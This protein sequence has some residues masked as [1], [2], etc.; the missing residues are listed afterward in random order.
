MPE[1]RYYSGP[2]ALMFTAK[3][4]EP[5]LWSLV[6]TMLWIAGL[7][8]FALLANRFLVSVPV[9][10][11]DRVIY[12]LAAGPLLLTALRRP[13][14]LQPAGSVEKVMAVYVAVILVSWGTTLPGKD[15]AG[16]KQDADF[17]LT[18]FVMPF[19]AFLIAR[20]TAWTRERILASLWVLVGGV[21][22][23][24]LL[25]GAMQYTYDWNFLVPEALQNI[26]PDRAKGPFENAVPYGVVLSMLVPLALF[27][28]VQVRERWV[29]IVPVVIAVGLVQSIIASKTRAV[30][31]ALPVALLFPWVRYP[32]VRLLSALLIADLALQVLLAPA[33][34][35]DPWGLR[36]RLLQPEPVYDRVA[37]SATASN[38]IEHR[39]LFGFGFGMF[40][41]RDDK[42]DYY[43]SWGGV[44]PQSA[45]FPNSP[46]NDLLNVLVLMGVFG[47]LAYVALLLASWQLLW[48]THARWRQI[49]PFAAELA[50]FVH[51][52]FLVLLVTGQF[53]A[54]MYMSFAQ[55]LF[56]FLLG[57]VAWEFAGAVQPAD[58]VW[59]RTAPHTAPEALSQQPPGVALSARG[60]P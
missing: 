60:E 1:S 6:L 44:S 3:Q 17:L 7:P 45:V 53:H 16:F 36:Q 5:G 32:R 40:T 20:N 14:S 33:V 24:L 58:L 51:A 43:T 27:L 9:L 39:P 48:R 8:T 49:N 26:H 23:Y 50:T 56:F 42:A 52:A 54:V 22:T 12:L 31:I 55:V 59:Q 35:V 15:L 2:H 11:A 25:F 21:G 19:T 30:W 57:I 18:C 28:Y 4:R 37:V 34:G 10:K 47:L 38:M 13:R 29:R 46:H 41:F